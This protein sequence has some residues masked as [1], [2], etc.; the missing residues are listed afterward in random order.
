MPRDH[1]PWGKSVTPESDHR[2]ADV[3]GKISRQ[4]FFSNVDAYHCRH[5][6]HFYAGRVEGHSE[7]PIVG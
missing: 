7:S 4:K 1:R 6:M 3:H 5:F 2:G